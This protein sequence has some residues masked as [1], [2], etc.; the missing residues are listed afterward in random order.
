MGKATLANSKSSSKSVYK[1]RVL[2]EEY[3]P[4]DQ[5]QFDLWNNLPLYGKVDDRGVPVYPAESNLAYITVARDDK[6]LAVLNFVAS[7]FTKMREHYQTIFRLNSD[8]GPTT[9]FSNDLKPSRAWESP[10][11]AYAKYIQ[12]FYDLLYSQ[13]LADLEQSPTIKNFDD[14]V[15]VLL[16]YVRQTG[17]AFTRLSFGE[18]RH[19]SVLNTGL[20]LEI[21]DGEYGNDR[22]SVDFINDPNFPI[23]EEL[24]RKYGFKIDRNA[25][26]R[27]VANIKS[28]NMLPFI[29]ERLPEGTNFSI[30]AVFKQFYIAYNSEAYFNEFIDYLRI[31]Y[32]TFYAT[33][34]EYKESVFN[35][36][37]LC[38]TIPFKLSARENP[39]SEKLD[40][41]LEQRLI[42][43]Y[44]FRLAEL[45][46]KASTKRRA[47]HLK[48]VTAIVRSIKDKNVATQKAIEYIQFNLGTAAFREVS[49]SKNNLTRQNGTAIIT[50]QTQFD[51]R[52]GENSR[53]L[54]DDLSSS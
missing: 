51:K 31:F 38:K 33:N 27:I 16:D 1:S 48:N 41:N 2:Y 42:L 40:L 53:Y 4:D 45:N 3:Y 6:Q 20:A 22:V 28:A 39:S 7:A 21:Y 29:T 44:D 5:S 47:F 18:S 52:T 37:P 11:I 46:L 10:I 13:V 35:A 54:T 12:G 43:F 36:D 30:D 15:L 23:Y 14:F 9:F 19:T 50:A 34:P 8:V 17:K 49:L 24:C 25:P 32:A 26:W